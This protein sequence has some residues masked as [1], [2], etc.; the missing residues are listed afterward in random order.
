[1]NRS[2]F[3]KTLIPLL[4][5]LA[6]LTA[7]PAYAAVSVKVSTDKEVYALGD[8]VTITGTV[9]EAAVA[10]PNVWVT[11][12][13]K[14]PTGRLAF[15]DIVKTDTAGTFTTSFRLAADRPAGVYT[16]KAYFGG[17]YGQA[18]FTV[19]KAPALSLTADKTALVVPAGWYDSAVLTVSSETGYNYAVNLTVVTAG[20]L[21]FELAKATGVPDF[22]SALVV[23][24]PLDATKGVYTATVN[25]T[26]GDG[27]VKTLNLTVA[28]VDTPEALASLAEV[29]G[30]LDEVSERLDGIETSLAALNATGAS[31]AADV[32]DL[33]MQVANVSSKVDQLSQDLSTLDDRLTVVSAKVDDVGSAVEDTKNAVGGISGASYAAAILALIAAIAA[34]YSV[35]VVTRKLAS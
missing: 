6:I 8:T 34:I 1:M 3:V 35:V 24:A 5:I 10:I 7:A 18:S 16:V 4:F 31:V 25:A 22:Q 19:S 14:E 30:K 11:V 29:S 9:K 17:A 2:T 28:V 32:K 27:T 13:V 23:Y 12:E 33:I 21:T 15:S 20:N 26:G